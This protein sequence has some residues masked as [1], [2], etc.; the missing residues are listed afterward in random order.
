M[1]HYKFHVPE[2]KQIRLIIHTDCKNEADDQY[3]VAHQLMTPKFHVPGIIAG[4]FE[5]KPRI[6]KGTTT[7]ASYDEIKKVLGLMHIEDE[8][9]VYMGAESPLEDARTPVPSEGAE[10]IIREAMRED[11]R[12]LYIGL[13]GALTDL[14]SANLGTSLNSSDNGY[15][16][17][18]SDHFVGS[19]TSCTDTYEEGTVAYCKQIA[20]E[21]EALPDD[22]KEGSIGITTNPAKWTPA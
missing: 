14:A 3:A 8:Y 19:I 6:E 12:P 16:I 11:K 10:F 7:K 9:Q 21:Y 20:E 15:D 5:G 18:K 4:H 13:Q 17:L 22:K 2:E 1:F